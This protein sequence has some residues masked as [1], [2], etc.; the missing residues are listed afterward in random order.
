[1]FNCEAGLTAH[2]VLPPS[3]ERVAFDGTGGRLAVDYADG[4]IRIWTVP[5]LAKS[6]TN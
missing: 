4:D 5:P 2:S 3:I 1:V 6:L